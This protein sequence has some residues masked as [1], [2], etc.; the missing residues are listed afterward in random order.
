MTEIKNRVERDAFR[1]IV[2]DFEEL[3]RRL[4]EVLEKLDMSWTELALQV[5]TNATDIV[6]LGV[7]VPDDT[8]PTTRT[9]TEITLSVADHAIFCDT[10][11]GD[12]T[13]TLPAGKNGREYRII[14]SGTST[15]SVTITPN[16]S[17]LLIGVNSSFTIEDGEVLIIVFE[18]TEG[19]G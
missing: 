4:T 14:N 7:E 2:T 8:I 6:A 16:G 9:T 13:V 17:D 1:G 19:W 15:N 5:D 18:T 3:R 11:G 12:I 10:D